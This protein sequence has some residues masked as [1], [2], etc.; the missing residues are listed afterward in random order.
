MTT[1]TGASLAAC[2]IA[3]AVMA[4]YL[5]KWWTGGRAV[6]D[7][8]TMAQGFINGALATICL[9]GLGGWLAG[10]AR[11]TAGGVGGKVVSSTTGTSAGTPMATASLGRLTPE[12]GCV[13]FLLF[14]ILIVSYKA[15]SKE[16]KGRLMGFVFAGAVLCVTAGVVGVLNGLPDLVNSLGTSGRNALEGNV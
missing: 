5:R 8:V 10:C 12:G 15:A 13:V 1:T 7:L 9:G 14:V 11:Q 16:D 2:L 4:V 6:K 3:I